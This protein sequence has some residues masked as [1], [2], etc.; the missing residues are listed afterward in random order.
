[1]RTTS[2]EVSRFF[3]DSTEGNLR[4][5]LTFQLERKV[6]LCATILED[7][8]LLRKLSDFNMIAKDAAYHSKCLLALYRRSKQKSC[9]L[10]D[11]ENVFEK[12]V[13][14]QVLAELVLYMEQNANE[15]K[16]Y[17]FKLA[18][19]PNLYKT[20]VR[21]LGGHTPDRVHTTKLKLII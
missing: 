13:H 12:Q 17:I 6:R 2:S 16:E 10:N 11:N 5:V 4:K 14:G 3:C 20:R 18:D 21:E 1:M 9:V 7:N 19:L 15:D 8:T